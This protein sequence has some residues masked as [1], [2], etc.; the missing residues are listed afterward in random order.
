MTR[1][2]RAKTLRS[3][4]IFYHAAGENQTFM[5]FSHRKRKRF[6]WFV[7][8]S[9]LSSQ[10]D[11]SPDKRPKKFS[12]RQQP[13]LHTRRSGACEG[14]ATLR[15]RP[16]LVEARADSQQHTPICCLCDHCEFGQVFLK[17]RYNQATTKTI[18]RVLQC[19]HLSFLPSHLTCHSM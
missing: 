11:N 5:S 17:M 2:K 8:L 12:K 9:W 6:V 13:L 19:Q 4:D 1:A 7:L 10:A 18:F 16:E 14:E 3:S 15:A